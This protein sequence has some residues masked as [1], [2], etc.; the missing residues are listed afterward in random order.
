M[1]SKQQKQ[2]KKTPI[3][4]REP[5]KEQQITMKPG[6]SGGMDSGSMDTAARLEL[7]RLENGNLRMR[8]ELARLNQGNVIEGS[9]IGPD[10]VID[11]MALYDPDSTIGKQITVF[12]RQTK[13]VTEPANLIGSANYA[14]WKE[15]VLSRARSVQAHFILNNK[16]IESPSKDEG[17]ILWKEQNGWLYNL[18]WNSVSPQAKIHVNK[19][20]D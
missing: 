12:L 18:I 17:K 7:A 20:Q 2:P 15:S 8:L 13:L 19:S 14:S 16:E 6:S 5:S 9:T 4:T 10:P 3:S 11:Q 1:G